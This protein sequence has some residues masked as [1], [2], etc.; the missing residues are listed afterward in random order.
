MSG[1]SKGRHDCR[2]HFVVRGARPVSEGIS[3][4][5][6]VLMALAVVFAGPPG[7]A[8][9]DVFTVGTVSVA[10]T[11]TSA[12][13][14]IYIR[15][16]SLTPVGN[17]QLPGRKF[18]GFAIK[19]VYGTG[20]GSTCV[21]NSTVSRTGT[22]L[23]PLD[24]AFYSP[25]KELGKSQSIVFKN[26]EINFIPGI[27]FT[28][29]AALP[30]DKIL[31]LVLSLNGACPAGTTLPLS[32]DVTLAYAGSDDNTGETVA[33]GTLSLVNGSLIILG[34]DLSV[35]QSGPANVESGGS[36]TYTI[37]VTNAN[38]A[39]SNVTLTDTLPAGA[40]FVSASPASGWSC[41]T[42]A[43]GTLGGTVTCTKGSMAISET[44]QFTVVVTAPTA[45][46]T[47]G[48]MANVATV[49]SSPA[50]ANVANNT[51]TAN[52]V[53]NATTP[54]A[55]PSSLSAVPNGN[56][57][58]DLSWNGTASSYRVLRAS[59]SGGPFLLIA[60]TSSPA[61]VDK[62]VQGD[63]AYYYVVQA[64]GT[65][66]S[67][68]SNEA[69]ATA[70]GACTNPPVL[71]GAAGV[72][73]VAGEPCKLRVYWLAGTSPCGGGLKYA[74]YRSTSSTFV[75]SVSNRVATN[76]SGLSYDDSNNL[77]AGT[78]YYYIVRATATANGVEETNLVRQTATPSACTTAAP[79]AASLLS[80]VSRNVANKLEWVNPA[81]NFTSS[82]IYWKTDTFPAFPGDGTE[83]GNY[84]GSP[85]AYGFAEHSGLL[86]GQRYY[87][88][89][90]SKNAAG[91]FSSGRASWGRPE[92]TL[93]PN[94]VKWIY[95]TGATAL[96]PAGI[97]P[98][99]SAYT[100][101]NDR[102]VHAMVA[103]PGGGSWPAGWKP[104]ATNGPVQNRPSVATLPTTTIGGTKQVAFIGS[105]DGHAYALNLETGAVIWR[106]SAQLGD[107]VQA[108]P[109]ALL[110]DFGGQYD[111]LLV[112]SRTPAGDSKFYGLNPQDGEILW[113]FD[114]G[115]GATG[116]G[117]ISS[118][119]RVVY[120]TNDNRV[121]FASRSRG[122]GSQDTLWCLRFTN[123][124]VERVWTRPLGDIDGSPVFANNRIYVGNNAGIVYALDADTGDTKWSYEATGDGP[125]KGFIWPQGSNLYFTTTNKLWA[126][127]DKG[128]SATPY[129]TPVVISGASTL[130]KSGERLWLGSGDGKLYQVGIPATA[131]GTPTVVSVT[132]GDGNAAVGDPSMDTGADLVIVGTDS[133]AVYAVRVPF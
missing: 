121:Y 28:V 130:L 45:C 66:L 117:I 5:G 22:I 133:G 110:T 118:Q 18:T 35:T 12:R 6:L 96:A 15:D 103:G 78:P 8:A 36:A 89:I 67:A 100:V 127:T 59:I 91:T 14:P 93:D 31:D 43:V 86:N 21:T 2:G 76:L 85:G 19:I 4:A 131:M 77:L 111:V 23:E 56:N 41:S 34:N 95:T 101:S 53:V 61:Y 13:V 90:F 73:Q 26:S 29:D 51:S 63:V 62:A 33:L 81:E 30:G 109:S 50:D 112:G 84:S 54:P 37:T 49:S 99:Q 128:N 123:A 72:L 20:P 42:P 40:A 46:G 126:L 74:V 87:Y 113:T 116:M 88:S 94:P 39:S 65:C 79:D 24:E 119:A 10:P 47:P 80:V 48:A 11:A 27:P 92:N 108:S 114:N 17:D 125:I 55:A 71:D 122:G 102:L 107:N 83:L 75:P 132:L 124:S 38:V 115:G 52:T 3:V 98:G 32:Q 9:T 70:I 57:R 68:Y 120:K 64:V 60:T 58:I 16:T 82:Q 69:S 25:A 129:F 97:R 44:G 7:S 105:Q 104:L 106:T 1:I